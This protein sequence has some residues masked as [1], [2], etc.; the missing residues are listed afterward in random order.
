[1]K[2]Y[3]TSFFN[4]S[5]KG[6]MLLNAFRE[7]M[8]S[9]V[10]IGT[11]VKP[12]VLLSLKEFDTT[13]SLKLL[14]SEVKGQPVPADFWGQHEYIFL[15]KVTIFFFDLVSYLKKMASNN[16]NHVLNLYLLFYQFLKNWKS[17]DL[18]TNLSLSNG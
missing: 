13:K 1:M 8:Y 15:F 9:A 11:L 10:G 2:N 12:G 14:I 4:W 5:I 16:E 18:F 3:V 6:K 7:S 17:I